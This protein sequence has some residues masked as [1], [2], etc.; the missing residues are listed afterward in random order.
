MRKWGQKIYNNLYSLKLNFEIQWSKNPSKRAGK[1]NKI[2]KQNCQKENKD[3]IYVFHFSF[4]FLSF[5]F[6][7]FRALPHS[8]W[9][10]PG[11]GSNRSCSCWPTPEPQQRQI[12]DAPETYTTAQ[13]NPGSLIHWA[14]PGIESATLW[15]L[16]RFASAE[17]RQELQHIYFSKRKQKP[18]RD[19]SQ[20]LLFWKIL[21]HISLCVKIC[22]KQDNRP[23]MELLMLSPNKT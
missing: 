1:V 15:S 7:L 2:K 5:V 11:W 8:I 9:R 21:I 16:V 22:W 20:V 18:N 4:F 3:N 19:N 23:K 17:P 6:C 12:Q 13:H 14:R 10:F